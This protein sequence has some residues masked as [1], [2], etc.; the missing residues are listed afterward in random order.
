M[1]ETRPT[2]IIPGLLSSFAILL[3]MGC[4]DGGSEPASTS[5]S[6]RAGS[7]DAG[8]VVAV[9]PPATPGASSSSSGTMKGRVETLTAAGPFEIVPEVIDFGAVAAGSINQGIF[10]LTNRGSRP[11]QVLR[12]TPSCVCT[13]LTDLAGTTIGPGETVAL[14][15]SLDAPKQAGEKEAK[16]FVQMQGM[17]QPAIVK[18]A[19]MVTLPIQ[20]TPAFASALKGTESGVIRLASTDGRSF[21]VIASNGSTPAY[22]DFDPARDDARATYDLRWSVQG[23]P[24]KT[25]PRWWVFTTDRADCPLVACRVRHAETGSR[26]D[27]TRMG[28]RWIIADDLADLGS[29]SIGEERDIAIELDHYNPRGGGTVD[30]PNWSSGMSVRSADPRVEATLA[31]S[32]KV[33]EERVAAVIRLRLKGPVE[34]LLYVPVTVTT[35]TGTGVLEVVARVGP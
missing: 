27:P 12:A 24:P 18:L 9:I 3:A 13:T 8:T 29:V 15:A 1:T 4:G 33:S 23:M 35:A 31:S 16:V 6:G 2:K 19:G 5:E 25:I 11:V 32:S 30:N 34:D 28:R 21:R 22:V 14:E 17:N 7:A 26:W 20:P 10:Q